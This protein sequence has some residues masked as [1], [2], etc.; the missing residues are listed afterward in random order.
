MY[1]TIYKPQTA[2]KA[3]ALSDFMDEWMETRTPPKNES[4]IIG[5][6]TL[7]D[8]YNLKVQEC[9]RTTSE[10]GSSPPQDQLRDSQ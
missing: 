7:S 8:P 6:S 2:I 4:W 5:S 1:D 10:T 9:D 3:Q